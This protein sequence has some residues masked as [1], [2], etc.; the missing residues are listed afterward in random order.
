MDRALAAKLTIMKVKMLFDT[1]ASSTETSLNSALAELAG[2]KI[3][4]IEWRA[5]P[6]LS[7]VYHYVMIQYCEP[8]AETY[9]SQNED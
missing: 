8:V 5:V 2:C 6:I 1:M 9:T 7:S 3:V 4:N